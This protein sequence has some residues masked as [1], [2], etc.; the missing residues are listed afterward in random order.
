MK[1]KNILIVICLMVSTQVWG[2]LARPDVELGS[3]EVKDV[4]KLYPRSQYF[5]QMQDCS[6]NGMGSAPTINNGNIPGSESSNPLIPGGV[7]GSIGNPDPGVVVIQPPG[8]TGNNGG[9]GAGGILS[10]G[11]IGVPG[12]GLVIMDQ[13]VNL[14][15]FVWQIVQSSRPTMRIS[16]YRAHGLPRGI[17]CWTDLE[18]WK[19][20]KSKVFTV[21]QKSKLGQSLAKFT[22][23]ISF[24]YGGNYNGTGRYLANVTVSPVDVKVAWG[25]DFGSEVHIPSVFNMGTKTNPLAAMQVFVYWNLGNSVRMEQKSQL[26][27]LTGDGQVQITPQN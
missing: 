15:Y 21:E 10:P 26:F 12:T 17:S 3:F 6:E 23:R 18:E 5:D 24:V 20:P 4:T 14:G 9:I 7:G 27:H 1:L 11:G 13:I 8:N 22:F 2:Q 19:M 16:T 25:V